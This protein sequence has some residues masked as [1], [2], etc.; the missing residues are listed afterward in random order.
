[1]C[2]ENRQR[3]IYHQYNVY[4]YVCAVWSHDFVYISKT[5]LSNA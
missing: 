3:K 2:G 1:M 5:L 4:V